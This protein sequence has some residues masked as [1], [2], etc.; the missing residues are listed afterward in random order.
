MY[1]RFMA[2]ALG[3]NSNLRMSILS[4]NKGIQTNLIQNMT[5]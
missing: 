2:V 3:I 4:G 1:N 5:F